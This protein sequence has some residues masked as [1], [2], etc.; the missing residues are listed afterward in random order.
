MTDE[1]DDLPPLSMAE[2]IASDVEE[3]TRTL[4]L[5]E[6]VTEQKAQ[7][8]MQALHWFAEVDPGKPVN[9]RINSCGGSAWD[10]SALVGAIACLPVEVHTYLHGMAASAAA[11]IW[12]AGDVRY[13]DNSS[14][15]LLHAHE[16]EPVRGTLA[17]HEAHVRT[18]RAWVDA[19]AEFLSQRSR[20]SERSRCR[21]L[22]TW[23]D[24]LGGV[25]PEVRLHGPQAI[26]DEF[27]CRPMMRGNRLR[28]RS[29]Q[30]PD[31]PPGDVVELIRRPGLAP[32][33]TPTRPEPGGQ[34]GPAA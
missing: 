19:T 27:D 20:W 13:A 5:F 25:L 28:A 12:V 17:Q 33:P 10:A 24:V 9:V 8:M 14:L 34:G 18:V 16:S 15:L 11:L 22:S 4:W 29:A 32:T 30:A 21:T 23:R 7:R 6:E 2:A 1:L 3:H 31:G 26:G